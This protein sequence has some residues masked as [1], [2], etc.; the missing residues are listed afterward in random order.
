MKR[1]GRMIQQIRIGDIPTIIW[2][3]RS[4]RVYLWVHGK[5]SRKEK[6]RSF[7]E[8]A[9]SKGYQVVSFDLPQHGERIHEADR[10]DIWNGIRD[11]TIV[12]EYVFFEWKDV[13]LYAC[14][15]GVYFVL[16]AY[17]NLTFKK[18]LFQSP[19]V[20]MEY[21]I[22]SM[23]SWFDVSEERLFREKEVNTPIDVLSW[24]Y[25]Q[26]VKAHPIEKW[27]NPTMI[28]YGGKDDLPSGEVIHNFADQFFCDL[29]IAENSEHAF[30]TEA[31]GIIVSE[32]L[33]SGI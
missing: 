7:A 9:N 28:L 11:L 22:R 2:G 15:L 14:S 18:C 20:D 21:L 6:A 1:N 26:F 33:N 3:A 27:D 31:D 13:S 16:H 5:M 4:D 17:Q 10:C 30:G 32:W 25:Y 23:M 29:L 24:D 8:I 19:I 12:A